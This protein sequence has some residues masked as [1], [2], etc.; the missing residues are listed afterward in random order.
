MPRLTHESAFALLKEPQE[1]QDGERV[2]EF[3]PQKKLSPS[4]TLFKASCT[5]SAPPRGHQGSHEPTNPPPPHLA[6]LYGKVDTWNGEFQT[7]LQQFFTHSISAWFFIRNHLSLT[8]FWVFHIRVDCFQDETLHLCLRCHPGT[9]L[10]FA[11]VSTVTPAELSQQPA[12]LHS[13][14]RVHYI[15]SLASRCH[16]AII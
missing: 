3:E 13:T 9:S 16:I 10:P 8:L 6:P 11:A 2:K 5:E 4:A 14:C 12:G 1:R 7:H 15:L